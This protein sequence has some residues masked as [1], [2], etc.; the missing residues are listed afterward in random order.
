MGWKLGRRG[1][2][3]RQKEMK[4]ERAEGGPNQHEEV[5]RDSDGNKWWKIK[6][7]WKRVERI[8]GTNV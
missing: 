2:K 6:I 3:K 7:R 1:R 8:P 4:E 5:E